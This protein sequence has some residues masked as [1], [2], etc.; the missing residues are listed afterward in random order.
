MADETGTNISKSFHPNVRQKDFSDFHVKGMANSGWGVKNRLSSIFDRE[1]G[2]TVML[3]FDHGYIMGPTSGL[4]RLDMVLP[5]MIPYVD[6]LMGT[7]GAIRTVVPP[8]NQ[9]PLALRASAGTTILT[10]LNDETIIDIDDA[11]RL[12]AATLAVMVAIGSKKYEGSTVKNLY[13]ICDL[14]NRYDIPIMGVNAV[15]KELTRDWRYLS[16]ATRVIAENGASIVKTYYCEENFENVTSGCPVPIVVAGGKKIPE[17]DALKLAYNA[18]TKGAAGVD[19]GRNIFQSE[20]PIA[21]IKAVKEVVHNNE[22]P[23]KAYQLFQDEKNRN[24]K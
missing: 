8:Y 12:N 17:F 21:M 10:E 4:E 3:A 15:G 5:K 11:I 18:V 1:S 14:G 16:L 13:S 19:M 22:T 6:C 2:R 7:R 23:E 20:D 24:E 9:K